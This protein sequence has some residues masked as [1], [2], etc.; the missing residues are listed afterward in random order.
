MI[1]MKNDLNLMFKLMDMGEPSK[2]VGIE[3]TQSENSITIKQEKYIEMILKNHIMSDVHAVK[4]PLDPN[5]KLEKNPEETD[6]DWSNSFAS[7]IGSLQYLA[8]A[9]RPDIAF[10]VNRLAAY[11]A[12]PNMSHWTAVKRILC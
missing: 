4:T 7:L 9:T 12:N 5:V 1:G 6:G 11:T 2:I 3:I 10:T 8:T